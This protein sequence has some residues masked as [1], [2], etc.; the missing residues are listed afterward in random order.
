MDPRYFE[1]AEFYHRRYNNFASKIII[2]TFCL[3]CFLVVFAIFATKEVVVSSTGSI[4]AYRTI[5]NIQSTSSKQIIV[6]H[7]KENKKVKKGELLLEYQ[8]KEGEIQLSTLQNQQKQLETQL[9]QL[10]ILLDSYQQ[11]KNLFKEKD[12]YGYEQTYI[13]YTKQ[14]ETLDKNIQQQNANIQAQNAAS[15]QTQQ[16]IQ[17]AMGEIQE[18]LSDYRQAKKAVQNNTGL[19]EQ[20]TAY[21]L[22]QSYQQQKD[23]EGA[24]TLKQQVLSQI[25]SQIASLEN[26]L[27]G[28]NIQYASSGV[29]Q[30]VS[31][32]FESQSAA[33]KAQAL[34]KSEQE[35]QALEKQLTEVKTNLQ[36][37]QQQAKENQIHAQEDGILHLIETE[38]K[39][40]AP[41]TVVA[42]LYPVIM[43][44]KKIKL[45]A[46]IPSKD[47]SHIKKGMPM[48]FTA[49]D[50][51]KDK[52]VLEAKI[53]NMDTSA[54]RTKQGNFFKVE[55]L[56][57]LNTQQAKRLSY[58]LEGKVT[59]ITH[60]TTYLNYLLDKV[61][62][63]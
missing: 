49:Y 58:G 54:T 13:D 32:T 46:Y 36:I 15:S 16:A 61:F 29:Q 22:Y 57:P 42:Q 28:Y 50:S 48:R 53:Q 24:D 23:Q 5:T 21:T 3:F 9:V 7:L 17:S 39:Y 59:L 45:V 1:S 4:E 34:A 35:K 44:A 56:V 25:D 19:N 8:G 41:G 10:Q 6:N 62:N 14:V 37:H 18:E 52:L 33:M 55:A 63:F 51:S 11:G 43:K 2:P 60:K 26:S 20:N 30:S 47:V 40:V 27:A 31:D 12:D 38:N